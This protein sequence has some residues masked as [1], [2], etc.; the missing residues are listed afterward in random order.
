MLGIKIIEV[1]G[2]EFGRI[3]GYSNSHFCLN[4]KLLQIDRRGKP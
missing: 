4:C 1:S 3:P 2:L